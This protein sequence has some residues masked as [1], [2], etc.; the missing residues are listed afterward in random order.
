MAG[1][2]PLGP[3]LV[4]HLDGS[5]HAKDR[6]EVILETIAGKLTIR[7]ACDRLGIEEAMFFRLRMQALQAAIRRLEPR[8][9]GRPPR[10]TTPE[11]ER[12]ADLEQDLQ[13][14]ELELQAAA[15]RLEIAQA[16][17]QLI[18]DEAG[19]KTNQRKQRRRQLQ[20]RKRRRGKRPR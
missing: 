1:R 12:I 15:V 17:P 4:H 16:M 13:D 2:K 6:M 10:V 3:Q 5:E 20:Q 19:K 18:E 7:E 14:K 9:S 11:G 8:P